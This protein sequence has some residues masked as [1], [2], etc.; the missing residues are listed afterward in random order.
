MTKTIDTPVD[1][2]TLWELYPIDDYCVIYRDPF[3]KKDLTHAHKKAKS[4][5]DSFSLEEKQEVDDKWIIEQ[6]N[7][8]I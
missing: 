2:I 1:I 5:Y 7:K 3:T 6:I 8:Y 4:I